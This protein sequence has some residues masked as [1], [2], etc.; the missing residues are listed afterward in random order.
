MDFS[1]PHLGFVMV[2]YGLF[3]V[4]LLGLL[5]HGLWR[6][7]QLRRDLQARGLNDPGVSS[8]KSDAKP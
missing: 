4:V 5:V 2:S 1:S 3:A 6:G 8:G 7:N